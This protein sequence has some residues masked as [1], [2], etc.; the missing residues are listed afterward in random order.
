MKR[1][2]LQFD[3]ITI[4]PD[5]F[6]NYFNTSIIKRAQQKKLIK[7]KIHNLRDWA[8]D[9]HKTVDDKPYG[10]G[11]GMIFKAEPIY[12]AVCSILRISNFQFPVSKQISKFKTQ[13]LKTRIVLLTP[14][15]KQFDQKIA[16]RYS[17]LDRLILI[18][19]HYE[20]VDARVKKFVDE[21]ISIG[22]YV[23]TGGELPAM[24]VVDAVTRLVPGVIRKESLEEESFS[25]KS[26]T[27]YKSKLI[28]NIRNSKKF[29]IRRGADEIYGEYPQYT[30]PEVLTIK[31]K[32]GKIKVLKVPKVLLSGNHQKI[33]EWRAKKSK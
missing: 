9:K 29:V 16:Y 14:A 15:E 28:T 6:E 8:R 2:F 22:P 13:N 7:I 4:F 20:G 33:K 32:Y 31:D 1:R 10:G 11:P 23:L 3:I 27:N 17:K 19:G 5:I 25:L 26:L 12:K 21:K 30:R 18:C 24:V